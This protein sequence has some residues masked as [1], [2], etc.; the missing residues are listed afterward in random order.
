MLKLRAS[1]NA[2]V[3]WSVCSHGRVGSH[4][5]PTLTH[6]NLDGSIVLMPAA[7]VRLAGQ[8]DTTAKRPPQNAMYR[9]TCMCIFVEEPPRSIFRSGGKMRRVLDGVEYR[10]ANDVEGV[11]HDKRD[12]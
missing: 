11:R 10:V 5:S 8:G 4:G 12:G 1:E 9:S 3:T 2:K 6:G 7:F